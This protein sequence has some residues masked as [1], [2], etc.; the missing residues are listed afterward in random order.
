MTYPPIPLIFHGPFIAQVSHIIPTVSSCSSMSRLRPLLFRRDLSCLQRTARVVG[1][2]VSTA[3]PFRFQSGTPLVRSHYLYGTSV[4]FSSAQSAS[5]LDLEQCKDLH[6][7]GKLDEAEKGYKALLE[8]R[9]SSL[10]ENHIDTLKVYG[11][12]SMLLLRKG[13]LDRAESMC[14]LTISGLMKHSGNDRFTMGAM[15]N[16]AGI[17]SAQKRFSEAEGGGLSCTYRIL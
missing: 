17:L 11:N 5:P 12:Y 2:S 14:R 7:E 15:S 9:K 16:L 13:D 4:R 6:F 3:S 8:S 10:G 1:T